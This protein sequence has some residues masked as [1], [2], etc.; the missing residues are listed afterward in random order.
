M[1]VLAF[2]SGTETKQSAWPLYSMGREP[3]Q[4]TWPLH[5]QDKEPIQ[6][7]SSNIQK[8][9]PNDGENSIDRQLS[10]QNVNKQLEHLTDSRNRYPFR[11]H[12]VGSV[13]HEHFETH[14][15]LHTLIN[16][17]SGQSMDSFDVR[18]TS[19]IDPSDKKK[20]VCDISS[21]SGGET[22]SDLVTVNQEVSNDSNEFPMSSDQSLSSYSQTS[23][24]ILQ[25]C[26]DN[27]SRSSA[28]TSS[29]NLIP[30]RT[31]SECPTSSC[32]NAFLG[33]ARQGKTTQC[34]NR[35]AGVGQVAISSSDQEVEARECS[36]PV[37]KSIPVSKPK[38][39]L[40]PCRICGEKA[41]GFHY[42]A[43]TCEACK[44]NYIDV[45]ASGFHYVVYACV[46][47]KV[48]LYTDV[49][50]DGYVVQW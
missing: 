17:S 49:K 32:S 43:N 15:K 40:P 31:L 35:T 45:K 38:N 30:D 14:D 5:Q 10:D 6:S 39:I 13:G 16:R 23:P 25:N 28:P 21:D 26:I 36:T 3:N 24:L 9:E 11:A 18:L 4:S 29:S 41:S 33:V 12:S 8:G 42:G 20:I 50:A 48:H 19:E 27:S 46:A 44:V 2:Q 7:T 37:A 34:S 22:N 1:S 47:C